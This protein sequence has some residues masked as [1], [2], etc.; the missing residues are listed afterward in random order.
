MVGETVKKLLSSMLTN[1]SIKDPRVSEAMTTI[2]DVSMSPDLQHARVYVSVFTD[3]QAVSGRVLDGL[4]SAA[5][6]IQRSL[7][8]QL[9]M[10]TTPRLSFELDESIARGAR[11]S[12]L[13]NEIADERA[14]AEP[15]ED[16]SNE[17]A[18]EELA[19]GEDG[20]SSDGTVEAPAP[21]EG[22][23]ER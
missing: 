19:A 23:D 4:R 3:D 1:G 2:T 5:G 13:L 17:D 8:R 16:G 14:P 22:D 10:R 18:A 6:T 9:D 7:G 15:E 21:G 11:I 12:A 20:G